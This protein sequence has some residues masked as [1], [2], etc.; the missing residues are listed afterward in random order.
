MLNFLRLL[1]ALAIVSLGF[2]QTARAAD[3]DT[4]YTVTY[5]EVHNAD[6]DKAAGLLRALAAASARENGVLRFETLQRIGHPD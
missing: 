4:Q 6:K 1:A 5:F 3:T 2:A